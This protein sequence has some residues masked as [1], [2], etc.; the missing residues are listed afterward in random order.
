LH[1][2]LGVAVESPAL[3]GGCWDGDAQLGPAG[4]VG[5]G[6]HADGREV[7]SA[8]EHLY[9]GRGRKVKLL[10]SDCHQG[11][12]IA[13][14][15]FAQVGRT[16]E[17]RLVSSANHRTTIS[18][19]LDMKLKGLAAAVAAVVTM[20]APAVS[21]A[22][23]INTSP[24]PTSVIVVGD[25]GMEFVYGAV[26]SPNAPCCSVQ[27]TLTQGFRLPT[28][29]EL[30]AGF[31]TLNSL[32]ADFNLLDDDDSNNRVAFQYFNNFDVAPSGNVGDVRAGYINNLNLGAGF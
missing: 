24:I 2:E 28:A 27:V 30:V 19:R 10:L 31:G 22:A 32:L 12:F 8:V 9:K 16:P 6:A 11:D 14:M 4:G 26:T 21:N 15:K 20:A 17:Y 13:G 3:P 1:D 29:E 23:V 18:K 7:S 5:G 25:N